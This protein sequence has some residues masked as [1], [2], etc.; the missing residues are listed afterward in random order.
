MKFDRTKLVGTGIAIVTPF[1]TNGNVDYKSLEKLVNHLIDGRVEYI[2]VQGTT[3]ESVTLTKKEKKETLAFIIEKTHGRVPIILGI[4]G[5]NTQQVI[6]DFKEFDLSK[7]DAILSVSPSY[8]KP[9]QEGIYQHFKL[10]SQHSPKPIILYNVP[11]RTSS[12]MSA[13]TTVRL[14]TDFKNIIAIKEASGNLA[15][16][17]DIIKK[18]PKNF[19]VIS[20]DDAITL[21]IIALGGN[22]V[23]SV[24]GNAFPKE[25]SNLVRH[26][27]R[28]DY[29]KARTLQYKLVDLIDMLFR[30]GNPGGVKA[31][32][33]ILGVTGDTMRLP[34]VNISNQLYKIIKYEVEAIKK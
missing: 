33:K 11:G 27:L 17:M 6:D 16:V 21:P 28:G 3:G 4:G 34:L 13:D 20:G 18:R 24:V 5:N 15:Q 19:L 9:T 26:C 1:D 32:L 30:E 23:I 2:V 7:V 31:A 22:G 10:V 29:E 12:N 14:A 25:F 8:N